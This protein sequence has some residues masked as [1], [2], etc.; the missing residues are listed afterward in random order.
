MARKVRQAIELLVGQ[1]AV[2][3]ALTDRVTSLS[4]DYY[5][6]RD[7]AS[8]S[9]CEE[10]NESR[11]RP[12]PHPVLRADPSECAANHDDERGIEARARQLP[13]QQ[14]S[15]CADG[16]RHGHRYGIGDSGGDHRPHWQAVHP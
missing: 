9:Y 14:A 6:A 7:L 10:T 3:S 1:T 4:R 15:I 13:C 2:E 12:S 16:A 11:C 8:A 5:E